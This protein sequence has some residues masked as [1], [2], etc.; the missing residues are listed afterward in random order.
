[1]KLKDILF[2]EEGNSNILLETGE[3]N[4][5]KIMQIGKI[6][7]DVIL[8]H[9]FYQFSFNDY[10]LN[11]ILSPIFITEEEL[12]ELSDKIEPFIPINNLLSSSS[13]PSLFSSSPPSINSF[14]S[15]S[16]SSPSI[17]YLSIPP[18]SPTSFSLSSPNSLSSS[19]LNSPSSSSST[20]SS[21]PTSPVATRKNSKI[22]KSFL[23]KSNNKKTNSNSAGNKSTKINQCENPLFQLHL[24]HPNFNLNKLKLKNNIN[25]NNNENNINNKNNENNKNNNKNNKND[26]SKMEFI[27]T[28][29][30]EEMIKELLKN[31]FNEYKKLSTSQIIKINFLQTE[32]QISEISAIS[33]FDWTKEN[34]LFILT[35]CWKIPL[36]YSNSIIEFTINQQ[37]NSDQF[38]DSNLNLFILIS[39]ITNRNLIEIGVIEIGIRLRFL[40]ESSHLF[41]LLSNINLNIHLNDEN[42]NLNNNNNN[43]DENNIKRRNSGNNNNNNNNLNNMNRIIDLKDISPRSLLNFSSSPNLSHYNNN[44]NNNINLNNNIN[45]NLNNNINNK[46]LNKS[47]DHNSNL[48]NNLNNLI[49]NKI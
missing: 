43:N 40:K 9:H 41:H 5:S 32:K 42:N 11:Q 33:P 1:M 4:T 15:I 25:N 39:Q 16:S 7:D 29:E 13:S 2:T 44:I 3:I 10:F 45:N 37:E 46:K 27:F 19:S 26:V 28:S 21:P 20:S 8:P 38:S 6:I 14:S 18:P 30:T 48:N 17:F 36:H 47:N 35:T 22:L 24:T 49:E 23:A 34:F 31:S 12:N